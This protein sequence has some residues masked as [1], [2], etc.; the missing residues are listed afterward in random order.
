MP[1]RLRQRLFT[2]SSDDNVNDL[3]QRFL[4]KTRRILT[5]SPATKA[6]LNLEQ[7]L[8]CEGEIFLSHSLRIRAQ[9]EDYRTSIYVS[10]GGIAD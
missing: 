8:E 10:T 9:D 1:L 4:K 6:R 2:V 7:D 5:F 3:I